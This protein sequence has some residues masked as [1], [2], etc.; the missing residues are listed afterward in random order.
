MQQHRPVWHPFDKPASI[1][2]DLYPLAALH[3]L[4]RDAGLLRLR[5]GVLTPTKAA[6]DDL[7]IIRRVR[8]SFPPGGFD[9]HLSERAVALLVVDGPMTLQQ[10][11]TAVH[12]VLGTRWS[13]NGQPLTEAHVRATL[14]HLSAALRA[15][16]LVDADHRTWRAGPSAT[17][18]LP[19]ATALAQI[20][21]ST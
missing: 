1:E 7:D 9:L 8:S 20:Y 14:S 18:L 12:P 10:L 5:N 21:Q 17:S 11:A 3:D 15:L 16:D 19:G 6:G 2:E 4:L 13:M